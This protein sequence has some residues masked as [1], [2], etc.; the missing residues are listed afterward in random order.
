MLQKEVVLLIDAPSPRYAC[1]QVTLELLG[2]QGRT[3]RGKATFLNGALQPHGAGNAL[4][5][6]NWVGAHASAPLRS[7]LGPGIGEGVERKV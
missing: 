2:L 4:G 5:D 7:T 1:E 3:G 6:G